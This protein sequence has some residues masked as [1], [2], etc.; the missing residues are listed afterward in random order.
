MILILTETPSVNKRKNSDD[1]ML[2][3]PMP[4]TSKEVVE[5]HASQTEGKQ[6]SDGKA[7]RSEVWVHFK[8]Q[9]NA[10]GKLNGRAV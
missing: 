10:D 6:E 8:K 1:L 4:S 2:P 7:D 3:P 9:K 5:L